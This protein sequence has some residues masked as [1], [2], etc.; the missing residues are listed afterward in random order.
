MPESP[1]RAS[2]GTGYS[3]LVFL[4]LESNL[5]YNLRHHY[6]DLYQNDSMVHNNA[7]ITSEYGEHLRIS[8][9]YY[10]SPNIRRRV[11]NRGVIAFRRSLP[12]LPHRSYIRDLPSPICSIDDKI[13]ICYPFDNYI[14]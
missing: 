7:L 2:L 5:C 9:T 3:G 8:L 4:W 14:P 12:F 13:G 11:N 6:S 1:L 10:S